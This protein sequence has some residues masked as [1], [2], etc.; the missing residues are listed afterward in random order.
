VAV[1]VVE[2][3]P[4]GTM[5]EL[6]PSRSSVLLLDSKTSVPPAGAAPLN[7]TVHVVEAPEFKLFGLQ[8]N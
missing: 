2:V 1:N 7:V 6:E 8:A 5:T 4:A 3:V